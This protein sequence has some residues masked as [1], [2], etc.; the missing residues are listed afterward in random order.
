MAREV[1]RYINKEDGLEAIIKEVDS[2]YGRYYLYLRDTD[3]DEVLPE[4]KWGFSIRT[5]KDYAAEFVT[6]IGGIT[7]AVAM[8]KGLMVRRYSKE[9]K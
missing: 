3:A 2:Q 9:S 7:E 5:L 4:G 1:V 6:G 8:K